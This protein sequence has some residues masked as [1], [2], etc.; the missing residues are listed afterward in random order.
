MLLHAGMTRSAVRGA[1]EPQVVEALM[2]GEERGT[3]SVLWVETSEQLDVVES[4]VVTHVAVPDVEVLAEEQVEGQVGGGRTLHQEALARFGSERVLVA[5][6]PEE[7]RALLWEA[8]ESSE[9]RAPDRGVGGF[10]RRTMRRL[11][12][13]GSG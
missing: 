13:R 9:D 10:M 6:G 11:R 12:G 1:L 3:S 5:P 4:A 2:R 7:A 8:G